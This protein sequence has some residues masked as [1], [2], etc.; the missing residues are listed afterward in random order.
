MTDKYI[1]MTAWIAGTYELT[2]D[3]CGWE[4]VRIG[5]TRSMEAVE[6]HLESHAR[7]QD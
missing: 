7:D 3:A 6:R 1:R 2:C 5:Y 4:A